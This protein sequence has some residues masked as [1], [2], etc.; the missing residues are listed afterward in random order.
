VINGHGAG[1]S[2]SAAEHAAARDALN[3]LGVL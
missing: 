1:T 2:K 3:N